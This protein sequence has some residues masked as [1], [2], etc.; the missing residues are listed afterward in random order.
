MS[1]ND[2]EFCKHF[3]NI[4]V[5]SSVS[6]VSQFSELADKM[7]INLRNVGIAMRNDRR[8][9][10][11]SYI[12]PGLGFTGGNIERDLKVVSNMISKKL[13]KSPILLDAIKKINIR[14]NNTPIDLIR[15][16]FKNLKNKKISFLGVTYKENTS[17]L[18]GSLAMIYAS[19]LQSYGAKIKIYD[20]DLNLKNKIGNI[21]VCNSVNKCLENADALIIVIAKKEYKNLSPALCK[22]LMKKNYIID[23]ANMLSPKKFIKEGFNY[24]GIGTGESN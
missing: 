4:Y 3:A 5:A 10:S 12:L 23:A 21:E 15:S 8:I 14:H 16:K 6:L 1:L 2:A 7:K 13:G 19:K 9:G 20:A 17:T 22:K 18:K 24:S 11:K